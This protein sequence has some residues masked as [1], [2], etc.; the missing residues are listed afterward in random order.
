MNDLPRIRHVSH[1]RPLA[2][3]AHLCSVCGQPI[4]IGSQYEKHTIVNC[5]ALG[6]KAHRLLTFK[7]HLPQCPPEANNA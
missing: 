1:S 5:D 6:R 7:W 3:V 4:A 2:A